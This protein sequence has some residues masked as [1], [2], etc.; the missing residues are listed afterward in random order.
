L[1][2]EQAIENRLEAGDFTEAKQII[3][4]IMACK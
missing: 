3:E 4:R 1:E 2:M